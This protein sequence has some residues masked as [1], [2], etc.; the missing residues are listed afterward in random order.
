M[1]KKPTNKLIKVFKPY[2]VNKKI[3]SIA[4]KMQYLCIAL[5]ATRGNEVAEDIIDNSKVSIVWVKQK[6]DY[7]FKK[8]Y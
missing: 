7:M 8:Q 1:G 5:P 3:M 2:Q 4:K 6:I